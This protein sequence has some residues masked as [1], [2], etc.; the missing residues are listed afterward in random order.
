V[1]E[2]RMLSRTFEHKREN[3]TRGWRKLHNAELHNVHSSP[4]IPSSR[5]RWETQVACMGDE[6]CIQLL[7]WKTLREDTT[8]NT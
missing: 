7:G 2:N 6:K 8:S 5:M 1:S 3:V 4:H